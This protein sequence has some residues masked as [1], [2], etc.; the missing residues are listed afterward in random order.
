MSEEITLKKIDEEVRKVYILQ[1][2]GVVR[3]LIAATVANLMNISD[4]P[5]WLLLIAGS[6]GGKTAL[7]GLLN[8]LPEY[9]HGIDTLTVNT[10]AS[11]FGGGDANSSLLHKANGGILVFK[12]FTTLTAMNK[13]GLKE[14]MG[15]FRAI[16]DGEFTK[17]TGNGKDITWTGKL[18]VIAGGTM[19]VQRKMRDFAE[20]GERF[21]NY[22]IDQPDPID[23]TLRAIRNRTSIKEKEEKLQEMVRDYVYDIMATK[24][25]G[26]T[27]ALRPEIEQ[28]I[29]EIANFAT[30][31]R[32]PVL[33][34]FKTNRVEFVPDREMGSRMA[35]MFANL[36]AAFMLLHPNG[37]LTNDDADIIYKC[38]LDSIPSD[39]RMILKLLT[40]YESSTT[41][42]IAINLNYPTDPI[43]SWCSQLNAIKIL[44]RAS[45]DK[46]TSDV[47]KLRPEYRKLISKF[48][49]IEMTDKPLEY[50]DTVLEKYDK[51]ES[52]MESAN[53]DETDESILSRIYGGGPTNDDGGWGSFGD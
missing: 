12:D 48:D 21:I 28:N 14:L 22:Y 29:A 26:V 3:L 27:R 7:M 32:S 46:G 38:A 36:T 30:L 11:G 39:R 41:K 17:K 33:L 52:E 45:P 20:Q 47:W 19:A 13:D 42:N 35:T 44:D 8:G 31:A 50:A 34:N 4:K 25:K 49:H 15:Q 9:I 51:Q 37:D 16:Y 43:L 5:V 2:K 18:G 1:D 24:D 40:K 53:L 6:S 23:M 10:F